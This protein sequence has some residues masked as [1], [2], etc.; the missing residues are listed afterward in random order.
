MPHPVRLTWLSVTLGLL[1]CS[2]P[3]SVHAGQ[4]EDEVAERLR[5]AER[6]V[7]ARVTGVAA[8]FDTNAHGDQLI[9]SRATLAVE[10][11]LR[12]RRADE[13]SVDIEGGTVGDLTL[14]VSDLPTL[15]PGERGV[16][17]LQPQDDGAFVP[18]RRGLGILKLDAADH[19]TGTGLT[20]AA[21]RSLAAGK[22]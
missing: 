5:G 7:V 18:H 9:V 22:P 11:T 15:Q 3:A 6:V 2:L 1:L 17:L 20:L 10:E 8:R 4:E 16:F 21:I 14:H 13:V 12:G 19:V